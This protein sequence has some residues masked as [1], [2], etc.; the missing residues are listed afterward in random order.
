MK[1]LVLEAINVSRDVI[2][3]A[4]RLTI[5]KDVSLKVGKGEALAVTGPSGSGKSTLISL[6][7][8]LDRSSS[9]NIMLAGSDLGV[10]D[11]DGRARL[12]AGRVGFVFQSFYLVDTLTA[13]EN[14]MLPLELADKDMPRQKAVEWLDR[15]GLADRRDHYPRQLSGG[16]QQRVAISRAFAVD[17]QILFADEPTGNLDD[18]ASEQVAELLF[19]LCG[20]RQ[21][22]LVLVTHDMA[23][24]SRCDKNLRLEKGHVSGPNQ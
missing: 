5:L 19:S 16:E 20:D 10:L 3:P 21:A 18:A 13:L 11:E 7:A 9:G 14:V 12:R 23:L 2:G 22:A 1:E 15:V 17:P 8:G 6:L 24:A 4:G